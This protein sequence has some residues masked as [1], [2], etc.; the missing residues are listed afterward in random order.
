MIT[1]LYSRGIPLKI[2]LPVGIVLDILLM[3]TLINT[4]RGI[5]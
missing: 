4:I 3:Y 2:A 5:A 1:I